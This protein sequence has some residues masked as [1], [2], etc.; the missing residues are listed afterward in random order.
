M[1]RFMKKALT[2]V[3]IITP[4]II[5]A[6]GTVVFQNLTGLVQQW[7]SASDSSLAPIPVGGGYVQLLTAAKG[8]PLLHPLG[9]YAPSSGFLPEY[10]SLDG[11]LAANPGWVV[12][13]SAFWDS[14]PVAPAP[15]N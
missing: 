9:S 12:A 15:I 1:N 10:S 5:F 7:R 14:T 11:F 3:L 4:S 13:W 6:Q 2:L 8:N